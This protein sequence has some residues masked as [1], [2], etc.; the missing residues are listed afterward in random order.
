[1]SKYGH[2]TSL[3]SLL[4]IEV[5]VPNQE[6]KGTCICVLWKSISSFG[7]LGFGTVPTMWYFFPFYPVH[8][9][10]SH[11]MF[12]DIGKQVPNIYH[13]LFSLFL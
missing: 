9:V 6:I 7:A 11:P 8:I 13:V 3:T 2:K 5:S 4:F 10:L 1:M 12:V